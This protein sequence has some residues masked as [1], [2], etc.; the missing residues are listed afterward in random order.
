METQKSKVY[1]LLDEGSRIVRCEGGYTM[2][3]IDDV[4]KWTYIDEGT[5]DR[6]NLCQS[7]YLDGGLY[8]YDGISRYKYEDGACVLRSEAEVEAD[9][10]ALPPPAPTQLD[11]VEAQV[12]Y[13]AMMTD[14][15]MEV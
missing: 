2:S 9:R 10:A 8:T 11:R 7:H 13:T 6:Y 12:T 15:L 5:G 4:S 1:V 3:N 14:T